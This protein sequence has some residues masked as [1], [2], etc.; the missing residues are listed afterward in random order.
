MSKTDKRTTPRSE[1]NVDATVQMLGVS[2]AANGRAFPVKVV[3]LSERGMRLQAADPMDAGQAVK[4]ELGDAMFLGEVC[5]C[6]PVAGDP[7]NSYFLGV[8]TH[9]CLNGLAGLHHLMRALAP[10]SARDL[11]RVR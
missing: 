4:I 9:E 1:I 8:I 2:A 7:G 10:E 6:A 11:E 5:Y 3:D